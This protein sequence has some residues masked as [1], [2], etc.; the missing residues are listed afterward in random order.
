MAVVHHREGLV[1]RLERQGGRSTRS[2]L[3]SAAVAGLRP[4]RAASPVGSQ[5]A[6][7]EAAMSAAA[8]CDSAMFRKRKT[9][10]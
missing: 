4:A 10:T 6:T 1:A 8:A 5:E 7:S 9:G 3:T 2:T